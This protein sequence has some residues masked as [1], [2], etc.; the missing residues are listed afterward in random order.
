MFY[1][2]R[3]PHWQPEPASGSLLFVTWRLAGSLPANLVRGAGAETGGKAFVAIDRQADQAVS[4][5]VWLKDARIA[6]VVTDALRHGERGQCFYSLRAWVIMP[7]HVHV[8]L[9]P[10]VGL[11]I[12]TRWLK[13]STARKANQILGR[14]GHPFWQD[15]S[16]D[17][18]IRND[19]EFNRIVRYIEYNPVSAGLAA[20]PSDWPW[21]SAWL[22]GES[23]CPTRSTDPVSEIN[24]LMD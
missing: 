1:H 5:P 4:G 21:Y 22:A 15:E 6:Q 13:G 23:A 10:K 2:R 12:V 18:W 11:P 7:N 9:E 17:H 14:T 19:R 8:L 20:T 3:L 24:S 16:F